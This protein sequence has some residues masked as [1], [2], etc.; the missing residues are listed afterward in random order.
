MVKKLQPR[1][2]KSLGYNLLHEWI[3]EFA[4]K[5]ASANGQLLKAENRS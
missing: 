1:N 3:E 4:L 5:A 2:E